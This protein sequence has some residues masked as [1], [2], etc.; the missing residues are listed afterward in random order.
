MLGSERIR[1]GAGPMTGDFIQQR[2]SVLYRNHH[3]P[4]RLYQLRKL[5]ALFFDNYSKCATRPSPPLEHFG[6]DNSTSR[7]AFSP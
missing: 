3:I 7:D 5:G 1:R 2:V 6:L 4:W